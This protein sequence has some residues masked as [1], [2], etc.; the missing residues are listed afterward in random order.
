MENLVDVEKTLVKESEE[1]QG[2]ISPIKNINMKDKNDPNHLS[3]SQTFVKNKGD[4][5]LTLSSRSKGKEVLRQSFK[6]VNKS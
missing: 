1:G 3:L 4:G 5:E 6:S 2:D